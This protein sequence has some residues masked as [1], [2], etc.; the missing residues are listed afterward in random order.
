MGCRIDQDDI[1][2]KR[3]IFCKC[4]LKEIYS[5]EKNGPL[6]GI[7]KEHDDYD[8]R[9]L[10]SNAFNDHQD[11]GILKPWIQKLRQEYPM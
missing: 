1:G 2:D 4:V 5:R 6:F 7:K 11:K 3:R 10:L 8:L 9:K